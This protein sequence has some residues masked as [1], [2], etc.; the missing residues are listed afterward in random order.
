MQIVERSTSQPSSQ[1]ILVVEDI[2]DARNSLQE[3][4]ELALPLLASHFAQKYGRQA[5]SPPTISSEAMDVLQKLTW[6][7]NIRQLE[8][9]IERAC[10]T[11]R[12]GIILPEP[13]PPDVA[14]G[15]GSKSGLQPVASQH[16]GQK[17]S[18]SN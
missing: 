15:S 3:L 2:E 16:Q 1:R 11:A 13:L 14:K 5:G 6:P 7:G 17:C 18:V 12:D 8:N 10:L 9:A 4:L